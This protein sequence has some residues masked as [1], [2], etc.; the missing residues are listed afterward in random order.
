MAK[1]IFG[2]IPGY[3]EGTYFASRLEL[4]HAGIHRPTQGGISGGAKEGADSIVVS[5]GYE[6]DRDLGNEITYVGHGG[7]D[8]ETGEQVGDQELTTGNLALIYSSRHGLPVRVVRGANGHSIYA[9]K[10]GYRYDGLYKVEDYW[11]QEGKSG[12]KIWCFRLGKI[13]PTTAPW[14]TAPP[15]HLKAKLTKG[16]SAVK[17]KT[18]NSRPRSSINQEQLPKPIPK[19]PTL[20]PPTLPKFDI[21]DRVKHPIFGDGVVSAVQ[22]LTQDQTVVVTFEEYGSKR[23][24]ASKANLH[25]VT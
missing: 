3:P 22:P 16:T 15:A 10:A 7:R 23:L 5:G 19:R 14:R 6:D 18:Q 17:R 12:H 4:S 20:E 25:R 21:G 8:P 24:L 11:Q 9:P 1:R 2:D 13:D